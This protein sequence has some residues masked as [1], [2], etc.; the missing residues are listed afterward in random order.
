MTREEFAAAVGLDGELLDPA[1]EMFCDELAIPRKTRAARCADL[2]A[3]LRRLG[4]PE[5]IVYT[6]AHELAKEHRR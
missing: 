5:E 6:A 1:H 3:G 2:A 4:V